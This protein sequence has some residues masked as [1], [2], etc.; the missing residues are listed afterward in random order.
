MAVALLFIYFIYSIYFIYCH[1]GCSPK[2]VRYTRTI[3]EM[4]HYTYLHYAAGIPVYMI[5][6]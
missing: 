5:D 3:L 6:Y 2:E 1:L 4:R